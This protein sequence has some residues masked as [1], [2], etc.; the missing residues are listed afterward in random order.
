MSY[1][2][3]RKITQ[4]MADEIK[5]RYEAISAGLSEETIQDLSL[6]HI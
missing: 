6:I 2:A 1:M 5:V 3:K 4:A